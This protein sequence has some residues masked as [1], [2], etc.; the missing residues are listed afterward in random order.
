MFSQKLLLPAFAVL[1]VAAAQTAVA[2]ICKQ[3]T[4]TINSNADATQYASCSTISGS[5]YV[6]PSASGQLNLDGPG[7][8]TGDLI[9]DSAANLVLLS[10]ASINSIGGTFNLT[11]LT[12]LST[13]QFNDLVSVKAIFFQALPNLNALMFPAVI[14]KADSVLISNTFLGSLTGIDLRT[15][16]TLEI[17]NNNRLTTFNT[18][19]ANITTSVDIAANGMGLNVTFPNLIWAANMTLRNISAI[20]IPSLETVKGSLG[21]YGNYMTSISAPNLTSVGNNGTG[22]GSLALV[23]NNLLTSLDLPLLMSVGG[24]DQIANNTALY[25]ISQ[26]VLSEVGGAIDF[27]GNFTIP[28][29]P[30]LAIVKGGFNVRSESPLDC[31]GF[32][33]EAG[34][35]K[36]IQGLFFCQGS[37]NNLG[38][39]GSATGTAS[40]SGSS[41]TSSKGA[42]VSYG[43]SEAAAGLSVLGGLLQMLL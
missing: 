2:S 34:S 33:N 37:T 35:G 12:T 10:S 39:L 15:V 14:S 32:Q 19:I 25:N 22:G 4:A 16:G 26:P 8:I 13:L 18:Q 9:V 3:A 36:A 23:E 28:N 27:V 29:L 41:S 43:V 7:Q 5:V 11:G 31:T 17:N 20:S 40:S 1:S 24:A 30:K 38:G 21:F 42:A 6:G